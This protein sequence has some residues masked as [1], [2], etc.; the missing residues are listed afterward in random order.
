MIMCL[1]LGSCVAES[2]CPVAAG[3]VHPGV[4]DEGWRDSGGEDVSH[5]W[6]TRASPPMKMRP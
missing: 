4:D 3:L 6:S 1:Y 5:V 2:R